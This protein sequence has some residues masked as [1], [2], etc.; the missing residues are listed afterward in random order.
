PL[1][2]VAGLAAAFGG[3]RRLRPTPLATATLC[4]W[5]LS[6]SVANET[7]SVNYF[8]ELVPLAC[9]AAAVSWSALARRGVER[10]FLAAG[11]ATLQLV[12]LF[13]LPNVVGVW[14]SFFPP[15]GYTP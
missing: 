1:L 3:L 11:L 12:L 15:H 14:P 5:L 9:A 4:A 13:H 8:L 2:L 6:F 10:A 7:S